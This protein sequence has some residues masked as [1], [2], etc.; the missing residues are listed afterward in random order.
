VQVIF[1]RPYRLSAIER[2][3]L[4]VPGVEQIEGWISANGSIINERGRGEQYDGAG[5]AGG[6]RVD[7]AEDHARPLA[8]AR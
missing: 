2:E 6:H 7:A 4:V 1:E 5:A 3:A 8:A